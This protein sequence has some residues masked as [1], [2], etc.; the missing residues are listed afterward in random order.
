MEKGEGGEE[1]EGL[2]RAFRGK[3][4]P[5]T[6]KNH[7]RILFT[8]GIG[9]GYVWY[10]QGQV[11]TGGKEVLHVT[12]AILLFRIPFTKPPTWGHREPLRYNDICASLD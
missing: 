8:E 2:S 6:T 10:V 1:R 7:L 5:R 3:G 11:N 4:R 9:K 12:K